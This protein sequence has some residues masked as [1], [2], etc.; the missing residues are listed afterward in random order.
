MKWETLKR[1]IAYQGFF[2]LEHHWIRHQLFSGEL[3]PELHRELINRGHA[4]AV[5]PYDATRD[6]V[7]LLEQFRIGAI[8]SSKGPWLT[9]IVAG[10]IEPGETSDQVARREAKE[11]AGCEFNEL[12]HVY[13]YYSSPGG[14]S[15]RVS[16]FVGSV[17]THGMGGTYGNIEEGEDIWVR[18][19]KSEEAFDMVRAGVIDSAMP[20]I[21]LQW[22]QINRDMLRARWG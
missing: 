3:G 4:A 13:D 10:L 7:V 14:S 22:L 6:T 21:A 16:L 20:I 2:R 17:D 8:E 9:E 12:V 11:E 5:L 19:I 15:E 1:V 18:V